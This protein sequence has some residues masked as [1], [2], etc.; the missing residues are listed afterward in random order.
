MIVRQNVTFWIDDE[1]TTDAAHG[2]R[3]LPPK[4]FIKWIA[5]MVAL[6]FIVRF[7][8]IRGWLQRVNIHDRGFHVARNL[9][10]GSR[11]C[12]RHARYRL[13]LILGDGRTSSEHRTDAN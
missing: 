6:I 12:V 5:R 8:H 9:D 7:G 11:Q 13:D 1:T 3:R 2:P 10:E 4:H